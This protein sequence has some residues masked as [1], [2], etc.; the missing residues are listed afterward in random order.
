M[1]DIFINITKINSQNFDI[2]VCGYGKSTSLVGGNEFDT[3]SGINLIRMVRS[4]AKKV[5]NTEQI[6]ASIFDQG[7]KDKA[8]V[9]IDFYLHP[10]TD[11]TYFYG[12]FPFDSNWASDDIATTS[13]AI[14]PVVV[15][16][17]AG[18]CCEYHLVT[19]EDKTTVESH[20]LD[21]SSGDI[22]KD[23]SV[24]FSAPSEAWNYIGMKLGWIS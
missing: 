24:D 23:E 5:A 1:S 22:V 13:I 15:V 12:L 7:E 6:A 4:L 14:D 11:E 16:G 17:Y 19:C 21:L 3:T 10:I 8:T 20:H 2:S 9:Q 18:G